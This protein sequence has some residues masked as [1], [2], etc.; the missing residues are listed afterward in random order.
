[1]SLIIYPYL[2]YFHEKK[3]NGAKRDLSSRFSFLL[4]RRQKTTSIINL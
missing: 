3:L 4:Y 2:S 1:M